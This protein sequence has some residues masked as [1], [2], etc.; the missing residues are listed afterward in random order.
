MHMYHSACML[1]QM[2]HV[3]IIILMYIHIFI[4]LPNII[5]KVYLFLLGLLCLVHVEN[6]FL[7]VHLLQSTKPNKKRSAT[8]SNITSSI[9]CFSHVYLGSLM[10][11]FIAWS[12]LA[13]DEISFSLSSSLKACF[14]SSWLAY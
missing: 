12:Q 11:C 9:A 6:L 2:Y 13:W 8:C 3:T 5:I 14:A 10:I 7:L 4:Y 1:C